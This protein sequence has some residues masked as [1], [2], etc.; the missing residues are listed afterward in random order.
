MDAM[1][2][3]CARLDVQKPGGKTLSRIMWHKGAVA[4]NRCI[5][6]IKADNKSAT[7]SN[8]ELA[9]MDYSHRRIQEVFRGHGVIPIRKI[10][11]IITFI[12]QRLLESPNEHAVPVHEISGKV[13]E[14]IMHDLE[15]LSDH[16]A[17]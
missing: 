17:S 12:A 4:A 2:T 16:S 3:T 5:A 10:A 8:M 7:N 6:T 9:S 1:L 15:C 13:D 11:L 14:P